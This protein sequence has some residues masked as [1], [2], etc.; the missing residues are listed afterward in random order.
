MDSER[1]AAIRAKH[2]SDWGCPG[3]AKCDKAT[4]LAEL[5]RVTEELKA[6]VE[7]GLEV[8]GSFFEALKPLHLDSIYVSNPGRHVTELIRERDEARATVRRLN[9]ALGITP[10]IRRRADAGDTP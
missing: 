10:E 6:D 1:V 8:S 5:D 2:T 4:L 3:A 7:V 9:A